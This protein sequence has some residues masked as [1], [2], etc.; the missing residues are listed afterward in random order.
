MNSI[1]QIV[2]VV[3]EGG[4]NQHGKP[5]LG[6]KHRISLGHYP[7]MTI[8]AACTKASSLID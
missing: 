3:G 4:V 5:L 6:K 1:E 7:L 8:V 2:R